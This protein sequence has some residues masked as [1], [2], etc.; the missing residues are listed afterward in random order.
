MTEQLLRL[1]DGDDVAIAL[2]P[3]ARGATVS[4]RGGSP[5]TVSADIPR[6]HKVA[7]R[8][9]RAGD[10]VRKYGHVIG[11]ATAADRGG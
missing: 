5:V 4:A 3:I 1:S 7:L 8:E 10:L 6:G 9:V 2:D 11:V